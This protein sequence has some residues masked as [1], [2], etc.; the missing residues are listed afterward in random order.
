MVI[1]S[2]CVDTLNGPCL[3]IIKVMVRTRS[4]SGF[5]LLEVAF[6]LALL[7]I[8]L[9]GLVATL[10]KIP[11]MDMAQDEEIVALQAAQTML[12]ALENQADTDF[13]N[14][15]ARYNH[16]DGDDPAT[17][18]SP[19][20]DFL[21]EGLQVWPDDEDGF[22]GEIEFPETNGELD[23]EAWAGTVLEIDA[24]STTISNSVDADEYRLLPV[25]IH[26]RFRAATGL[27][28]IKTIETTL[29]GVRE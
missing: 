2:S 19:G 15:W 13:E 28:L 23:E 10:A 18:T 5:T 12:E 11:I 9:V 3:A 22:C 4:R 1:Y 24:D 26:V 29:Y 25:R 21:V 20:P 14:L 27:E 16:D 6:V 8:A 7:G 17:G